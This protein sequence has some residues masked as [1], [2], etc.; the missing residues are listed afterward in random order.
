MLSLRRTVQILASFLIN[1]EVPVNQMI[2]FSMLS[3]FAAGAIHAVHM[4]KAYSQEWN[5][6]G[7]CNSGDVILARD[8]KFYDPCMRRGGCSEPW[9]YKGTY[10]LLSDGVIE[11]YWRND[12]GHR[13]SST[14]T[15]RRLLKVKCTG[16]P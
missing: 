9:N 7:K 2:K 14:Y 13:R 3:L 16:F 15:H 6:F 5:Y 10:R 8:G 12:S 1:P 11:V 4:A